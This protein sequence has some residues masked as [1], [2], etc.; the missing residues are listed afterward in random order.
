MSLSRLRVGELLALAGSIALFALMFATW[1]APE[2]TLLRSP[3]A[4]VP[5]SVGPTAD[6]VVNGFVDRYAESGWSTLG[7]F[8]VLLLVLMMLGGLALAALT[9]TERD[10]PVLAVV[11]FVWTSFV[12]II[13][14]V[15]LLIRL[16]LAQPSLELGFPDS[17]VDVRGAAWLGL[18]ALIA[19]TVG[20]WIAMG[21]ERTDAS[22]SVA[23]DVPVRPAPPAVA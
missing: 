12:G 11:A 6:A 19:I 17:Q 18:L 23:P 13:T 9:A 16:T 8:M 7:W 21:D 4:D 20:A 3:G 5:A 10:T 22:T 1:A 15:I 2:D 14:S